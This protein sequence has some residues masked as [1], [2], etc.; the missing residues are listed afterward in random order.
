MMQAEFVEVKRLKFFR[1]TAALRELWLLNALNSGSRLSQRDLARRADLSIS[2]VNGYLRRFVERG[3]VQS[4]MLNRRDRFYG[5]TEAG[6]RHLSDAYFAY[7]RESFVL[8]SHAKRRLVERLQE[9]HLRHQLQRVAIYPAGEVAELVVSAVRETPLEVMALIDDD[10]VKQ[11]RNF[12]GY[13]VLARDSLE[14]L[15]LDGI[16]I[17]TYRYRDELMHKVRHLETAGVKVVGI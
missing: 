3:W 1:P 2:V 15:E 7:L 14:K 12:W 6:K 16:I 4:E 13:P 9:L 8:F 5:L 11:G 17:A 10:P